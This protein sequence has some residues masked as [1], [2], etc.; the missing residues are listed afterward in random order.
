MYRI[1]V[2]LPFAL[3]IYC[4][5]VIVMGNGTGVIGNGEPGAEVEEARARE[6]FEWMRLRDP[7][8]GEIPRAIRRDEYL[9]ARSLPTRLGRGLLKGSGAPGYEW[10]GRGPS[11]IGG[12]TRALGID[13]DHSNVLVAGGITGGMWRSTD[14]GLTWNRTTLKGQMPSVTCLVQDPRAGHRN[15]WYHGTGEGR[16]NSTR[17]GNVGLL[18]DGIYR[19]I[20][21]AKSWEPLPSTVTNTPQ[22]LDGIFDIVW[23]IAIDPTSTGAGTIYAAAAGRVMRSTDGGSSWSV[24]VGDGTNSL[25]FTAVTVTSTG[26][27]YAA[28][29][30]GSQKGIWRSSNGTDWTN[31]ASPTWPD[32]M[33]RVILAVAPSSENILYVFSETPGYGT[34]I[35]GSY[36]FDEYYS[37]WKYRYVGGNG[38]GSGGEWSDRSENIPMLGNSWN[39]N[40]LNSYAMLLKV[41]PLDTNIVYLG[42]TNL[43]RSDDGFASAESVVWKGGYGKN[44]NWG[45]VGQLHPDQHVLVFDPGSPSTLLSGSDGGLAEG[46]EGPGDSVYWTS[47]NNGFVTTQFYTVAID[48][49]TFGSPLLLGGLQDNGTPIVW[50]DDPVTPWEL[51]NG[52]DGSFCAVADSGR[53][54][55]ASSQGGIVRRIRADAPGNYSDYAVITPQS[56]S[57]FLFI[58]PFVL[59]PSDRKTMYFPAGTSLWRNSNLDDISSGNPGRTSI[60]WSV[61]DQ[62]TRRT[63]SAVGV[64]TNSPQSRLYYGTTDGALYRVDNAR[65]VQPSAREVTG[66]AF[67]VGGYVNCVA[68]DPHDGDNALVV[69]TNYGVQSLFY[70]E[71]GG[72]SWIPVG[73]NLEENADGS[74]RGPSCRWAEIGWH[75]GKRYV[76]V[77]TTVGLFSATELDGPNTTWVLEGDGTIGYVRVDM[78]TM[79]ESDGVVAVATWGNGMYTT[80]LPTSEVAREASERGTVAAYPNPTSGRTVVSFELASAASTDLLIYDARGALVDR[81]PSAYLDAGR[82]EIVFDASGLPSGAY[83]YSVRSGRGRWNGKMVV[84]R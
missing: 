25:G 8:T 56:S 60:N 43:Y 65:G 74:G 11:N 24:A 73:G 45:D 12:R 77:G 68:V 64:S 41:H 52:G 26:I 30:G 51:I 61:I 67:P 15:V 4:S 59:D 50:D 19:S 48:Q 83:Y 13:L 34:I 80:A 21:S 1:A 32:S 40:G 55:Y 38:T 9:F 42:G 75:D 49:E 20:D 10:T 46:V 69:F 3:F 63:I 18:G 44:G 53:T 58:A 84:G 36:G 76:F 70:T 7:R 78:I 23:D 47:K 16:T 81:T 5:V 6:E 35:T 37:L 2:A 71:D 27:V 14:R 62:T 17:F 39:Y 29:A 28:V 33:R 79:R 66:A 72:L 57:G 82:H 54:I 31:I 22:V